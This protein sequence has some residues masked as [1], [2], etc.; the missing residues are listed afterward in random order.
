MRLAL[1]AALLASAVVLAG[2]I[3]YELMSP[4]DPASVTVAPIA[5]HLPRAVA[6]TPF[7][8]PPVDSFA[9]IDA[10]PVFSSYRKPLVDS[11]LAQGPTG[12]PSDLSLVGVIIDGSHAVALLR[13]KS[14]SNSSSAVVGGVVNGWRVARIDPTSVTLHSGS[15]DFVVTLEG[16]SDRPPSAPLQP[17]QSNWSVTAPAPPPVAPTSPLASPNTAT[18]AP[19]PPNTVATPARA[20]PPPH[21]AGTTAPE[22]LRSAPRDPTTGEPTL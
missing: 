16:P 20:P 7:V 8:P 11:A 18:P 22:A 21:S 15:G 1:P 6:H 14:T 17:A 19:S 12:A 13:S 2:A 4:L 3:G 5:R 9:E 10:R